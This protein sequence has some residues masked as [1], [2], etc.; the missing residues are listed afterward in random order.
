MRIDPAV[1][2]SVYAALAL[3]C[4]GMSQD[5]G[6]ACN[7]FY[8]CWWGI[9]GGWAVALVAMQAARYGYGGIPGRG[10]AAGWAG[11]AAGFAVTAVIGGNFAWRC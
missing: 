4:L 5:R 7:R 1:R 6:W 9:A 10:L 2:V 11:A 3:Y 8:E